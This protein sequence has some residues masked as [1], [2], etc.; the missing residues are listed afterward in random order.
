MKKILFICLCHFAYTANSQGAF[1][2]K[3]EP[4][5]AFIFDITVKRQFPGADL[6]DRFGKNAS[7]GLDFSYKTRGNWL[8]TVGGH[9]IFGKDVKEIGILDS[10]KGKTTGEIIDQNG[11]FAVI[12]LDQRGMYWG[13]TIS[14]II[15]L[16]KTNRNS[17]IYLS[18]G[19]GYLQHRIRIYSTNT[20][21]Q[22][23]DEYKKGYDRL[24]FGPALSQGIGYRFLD[25]KKQLN[26]TVGFELIEGF[27]QNRRSYNFDT[28][29]ADTNKRLDLMYGLKIALC[30]PLYPKKAADEEFFE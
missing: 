16:G 5:N 8:F 14:K 4:K 22:L 9:F 21:P 25:P 12:G 28:R 18:A 24:T 17:G 6:A 7:L 10:L 19:G 30:V 15:P 26:F 2:R 1:K 29:I 23:T 27:T 3:F 11:Q 13:A 20:V